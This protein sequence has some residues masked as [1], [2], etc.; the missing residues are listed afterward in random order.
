MGRTAS[1]GTKTA[2]QLRLG[3]WIRRP[4]G[5]V[6]ARAEALVARFI[7]CPNHGGAY[8]IGSHRGTANVSVDQRDCKRV[9]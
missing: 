4:M 6:A 1:T 9:G 7:Q 8:V 5:R 2:K 3:D